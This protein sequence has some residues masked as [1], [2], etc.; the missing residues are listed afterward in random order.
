VLFYEPGQYLSDPIKILKI[1]EGGLASHGAAIGIL[2]AIWLYSSYYINISFK[3]FTI[4]KRKRPG[5]SFLWVVDKIVIVVALGGSLIRLGNFL[6]SEIV[7]V[8]TNSGAG[9][10][11]AWDAERIFEHEAYIEDV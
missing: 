11:F 1:W 8:E 6:N 3:E 9:V 5:Q 2:T 10:V 4:K 7:G